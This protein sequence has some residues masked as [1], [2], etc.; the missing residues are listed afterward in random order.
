MESDVTL[1]QMLGI[2]VGGTI[3]CVLLAVVIIRIGEQ[4][5]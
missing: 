1:W 2:V 5:L 4:L 3:A